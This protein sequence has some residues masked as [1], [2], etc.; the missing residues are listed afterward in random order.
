M[1]KFPSQALVM[2]QKIFYLMLKRLLKSQRRIKSNK[3]YFIIE[4]SR[5]NLS[6]DELE[7][8]AQHTENSYIRHPVFLID[9]DKDVEELTEQL[10]IADT[11]NICFIKGDFYTYYQEKGKLGEGTS[12]TVKK[13][14]KVGTNEQY[15]VKIVHYKNDT[16]LVVLV[17][18]IIFI[19]L[20]F[21]QIVNEFKN[22]S[23]LNHR[24]IIKVYKL[25]IDYFSKKIYMVMELADCKE[26]LEVIKNLGHYSGNFTFLLFILKKFRGYS[27]I[28]L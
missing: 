2:S 24:N 25:Y 11:P 28:D 22:H 4:A 16:E 19:S 26:M 6:K 15:A 18:Y 13:C 23:K 1:K 27:I 10:Q 8:H 12:G 7:T 20:T 5:S 21:H 3:V 17:L 14:V 9:M